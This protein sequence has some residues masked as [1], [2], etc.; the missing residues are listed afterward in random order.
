[1]FL[2][3]IPLDISN[4][5]TLK[6]L[7]APSRFHG[8]LENCF[9]DQRTRKLWRLDSVNGQLYFLTLTKTA[10]DF[11][12]FCRQFAKEGASWETKS[13]VHFLE[14]IQKESVW[15]FR[16]TANPTMC[17]PAKEKTE[18]GKKY[19]LATTEAQKIWLIKKSNTCGF[20]VDLDH[21]EITQKQWYCFPKKNNWTLSILAVSYEGILQ[22]TDVQKFKMALTDGIGRS[23]AYGMGLMTI[24]H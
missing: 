8:A 22:V 15:R 9:N 10:P 5:N 23:K 7:N 18:R 11:S 3:R 21:F 12:E 13:Y 19:A 24:I 6:A 16:L 20:H 1:M 4:R 2:S 14:G 17:I